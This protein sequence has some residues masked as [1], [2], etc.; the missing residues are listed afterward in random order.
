MVH[1]ELDAALLL[2]TFLG[3]REVHR[4]WWQVVD[5][6]DLLLEDVERVLSEAVRRIKLLDLEVKIVEAL[7]ARRLTGLISNRVRERRL[8][9]ASDL[10]YLEELTAPDAR[11]R[12]VDDRTELQ[13]NLFPTQSILFSEELNER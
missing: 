2:L 4:Q 9:T 8:L 5:D 7:N 13:V 3:D 1:D 11:L 6:L 12:L 10:R